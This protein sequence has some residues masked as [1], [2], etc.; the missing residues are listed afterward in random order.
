[1]PAA[2]PPNGTIHFENISREGFSA[3]LNVPNW[4]T[5]QNVTSIVLH[6]HHQATA[7]ETPALKDE[8]KCEAGTSKA[9]AKF[10]KAK[11]ACIKKCFTKARK[12]GGPYDECWAPYGGATATCIFDAKKGVEGKALKSIGK[13]CEKACPTCYASGG[14]CPDGAG[15]VAMTEDH[16]DDASPLIYCVESFGAHC[17]ARRSRSARTPSRRA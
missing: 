16:V 5:S 12:A 14:N 15:F 13:A 3:E 4:A 1:M 11:G 7:L 10:V 17:P 2:I 6:A 9:L 8:L